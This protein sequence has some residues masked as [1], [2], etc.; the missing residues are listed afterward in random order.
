MSGT[1]VHLLGYRSGLGSSGVRDRRRDSD[2]CDELIV[3][4]TVDCTHDQ[5]GVLDYRR[6]CDMGDSHGGFWF[7]NVWM[8][9]ET[10]AGISLVYF[11]LVWVGA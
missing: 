11:F 6:L 9:V 4:V 3:H 5:S 10:L 8:V 2:L 7:Y 1:S